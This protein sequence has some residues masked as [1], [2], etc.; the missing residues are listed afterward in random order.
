MSIRDWFR[1]GAAAAGEMPFLDHLEELRWRVVYSLSA[2]IVGTAI[3]LWAV[4][5]FGI[6]G[7]LIE[8]VIPYLEEGRLNYFDPITPFM[9]YFKL[10]VV[11]G[12]VLAL[13]VIVYQIWGFLSPG[14]TAK[15]KKWI[16]PSLYF[17]VVLFAVGVS[18]AYFWVLPITFEVLTGFQSE[19]LTNEMEVNRY[20][21]FV[22][23]L[24]LGFGFVFELPVVIMIL[25]AMGL[26]TPRFLREKRRHAIVVLT[27]VSIILTPADLIS[28]LMMM[29]PLLFLYELSIFLSALIYR[30]KAEA[31]EEEERS[32]A[33]PVVEKPVG[34]VSVD[35]EDE[36]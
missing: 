13:P 26:V 21:S 12:F 33:P 27:V 28:A 14:L 30:K 18:M 9:V 7:I 19:Y 11:L 31:R 10:S 8:P 36:E 22:T 25:S 1:R 6:M 29:V 2:L 15:E 32:I 5:Y 20:L 34:T 16:V 24:L 3:G 4:D 17:G 35:S 23:K